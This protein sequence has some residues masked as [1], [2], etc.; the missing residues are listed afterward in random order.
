MSVKN[1]LCFGDSNT[2]GFVPGAYDPITGYMERY[3]LAKRWPGV[4]SKILGKEYHI[5]EEGLNGRT[6]NVEYP[7]IVGRSGTSYVLPCLYSHSPLDIIILQLGINDIKIIFDRGMIEISEGI[8]EIID[9]IIGT[10][11]GRDMQSPPKILLMSPPPLAH[12][13]YLDQ[14]GKLIFEG[15]ME[16]SLQFH[17]HYSQIAKDKG[18][19]YIN[20]SSVVEYSKIDGLHLDEEGHGIVGFV[21]ASKIKEI[22]TL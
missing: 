3:P 7:D 15:G 11:F 17:D 4:M 10:L 21:T 16:K 12:E 5:I 13:G 20:L 22:F 19:Y 14:E 18:C 8:I 9:M 2:W 6:T 1:I